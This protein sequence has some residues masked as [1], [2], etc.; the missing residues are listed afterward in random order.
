MN[1]NKFTMQLRWYLSLSRRFNRDYSEAI[2]ALLNGAVR[3]AIEDNPGVDV[4][5][6]HEEF[7]R[8]I[9]VEKRVYGVP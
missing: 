9:N 4:A 8:I 6:M 1:T 7:H 2:D 5:A 3:R